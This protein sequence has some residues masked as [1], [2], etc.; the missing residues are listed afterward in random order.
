MNKHKTIGVLAA[1]LAVAASLA[2]S[3]ATANLGPAMCLD[4]HFCM[5]AAPDGRVQTTVPLRHDE[6]R[7]TLGTYSPQQATCNGN[8]C[9]ITSD[10]ATRYVV[11]ADRLNLGRALVVLS[12]IS[13]DMPLWST[14][15]SVTPY[16]L[17]AGGW[18]AVQT[19]ILDCAGGANTAPNAYFRVRDGAS[20]RWSKP[21]Y[22]T[23]GCA[24]L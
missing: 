19:G 5:P 6:V 16:G 3:T 2:V 22:V 14:S 17:A 10:Y 24:T 15:V 18:L 7:V 13:D 12:R 4:G 21:Q 11:R 9:T 23:T 8:V 1:A 20:G